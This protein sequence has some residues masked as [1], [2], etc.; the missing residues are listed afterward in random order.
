MRFLKVRR[1]TLPAE[2]THPPVVIIDR[3]S[4]NRRSG[5]VAGIGAGTLSIESYFISEMA[6]VVAVVV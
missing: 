2:P 6:V 4:E 5:R 3:G 1:L